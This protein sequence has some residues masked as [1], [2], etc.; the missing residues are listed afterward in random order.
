LTTEPT[1]DLAPVWSPDGHWIAFLR[2]RGSSQAAIVI[3]PSL[4]GQERQLAQIALDTQEFVRQ[5]RSHGLSPPLL[6]WALDGRW[7]L[8][9]DRK[10]TNAPYSIVRVSMETGEKR[11]LISPSIR[12]ESDGGLAVSPDG[13][14]LAFTR[15]VGLFERDL[16]IVPLSEDML[17]S[18]EP[19]R[20]TFDEKEIDGVAWTAD[21]HGLVFSSDRGGRREL[22]D[23]AEVPSGQT[24]RITAAGDDPRDVAIARAGGHLVY[25]HHM[26]NA[27]MCCMALNPKNGEQAH[28]L[29]PS[30][31]A[32]G[33]SRYSPDGQRIAFQSNRSGRDEIWISQADGSHPFQLTALHARGGSPRW[34]P[35][36]QKIAFDSN[37]AGRWG[38]FLISAQGGQPV[39][40]TTNEANS[41][42]PSWSHDGK[43]I[44]YS[45]KRAERPQIWKIPA[46]GGTELQVTKNGGAV[47]FE[48]AD[49]KDLWYTK[50]RELWK[51]PVRG[52]DERRI[53]ASLFRDSFAPT[54]TGVYFLEGPLSPSE[55][56]VRLQF[57][58]FAT[59]TIK[60]VA[61]MPAP[62]AGEICVSPDDKW[63]VFVKDD[64]KG[65]ELMLIENFR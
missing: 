26:A 35:D 43:W 45:S 41:Y 27:H 10:S 48:S 61:V 37:A 31:R 18:A 56:N 12:N 38:I 58:E 65:S 25:S 46:T 11:I 33:G 7:L 42:R 19:I 29:A 47:P 2:A 4:G 24:V 13:K 22:W 53:S 40:L 36:G 15:T 28:P 16:Y 32:N 59:Q 21:G 62:A 30:T 39:R 8:S 1:T 44:Y 55:V 3:I 20:L 51:A 50:E 6:A 17:T 49:G 14:T 57:L 60:T 9:V 52:G 34:S 54:K 23:M 63:M 64:R 5:E